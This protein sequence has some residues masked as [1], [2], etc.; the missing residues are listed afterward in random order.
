MRGHSML[1]RRIRPAVLALAMIAGAALPSTASAQA[2]A[3]ERASYRDSVST[4]IVQAAIVSTLAGEL[5]RLVDD[6][7]HVGYE[8]R[9]PTAPSPIRWAAIERELT[10]L[11]RARPLREDEGVR[12]VI[13]VTAARLS[14]DSLSIDFTVSLHRRCPGTNRLAGGSTGYEVRMAWAE[15]SFTPEAKAMEFTDAIGCAPPAS[16]PR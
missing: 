4:R 9:F 5:A 10:R 8:F 13:A 7:S 1:R 12:R 16:G 14:A 2:R 3:W 15:F 11:L 6:T